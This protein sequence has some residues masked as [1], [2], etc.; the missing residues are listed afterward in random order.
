M[1]ISS[2]CKQREVGTTWIDTSIQTVNNCERQDIRVN[3]VFDKIQWLIGREREKHE[4]EC[5]QNIS[6]STVAFICK[7]IE[8][9]FSLARQPDFSE[10]FVFLNIKKAENQPKIQVRYN[11]EKLEVIVKIKNLGEVIRGRSKNFNKAFCICFDVNTAEVASISCIARGRL[12]VYSKKG[13]LDLQREKIAGI[14]MQGSEFVQRITSVHEYDGKDDKKKCIF[15]SDWRNGNLL[16]LVDG[17]QI[18]SN[19]VKNVFFSLIIRLLEDFHRNGFVHGN[20]RGRKIFYDRNIID[21]EYEFYYGNF[22]NIN[23][24][25]FKL[26]PYSYGYGSRPPEAYKGVSEDVNGFSADVWALGSVLYFVYFGKTPSWSWLT[27]YYEC[28]GDM[29]E[30]IEKSE[31]YESKESKNV[32]TEKSVKLF[33][34]YLERLKHLYAEETTEE[35]KT[36]FSKEF[37]A[38]LR[39]VEKLTCYKGALQEMRD[40]ILKRLD[41]EWHKQIMNCEKWLLDENQPICVKVLAH[42]LNPDPTKRKTLQELV[43]F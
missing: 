3:T 25:S 13:L 5:L 43:E 39:S 33:R 18:D 9:L 17:A 16:D 6:K 12:N 2:D 1:L 30:Q 11:R 34:D 21:S 23:Q 32:E 29:L 38:Y 22:I 36:V 37:F 7:K 31:F 4:R 26:S 42:M 40:F 35:E 28:L 27:H 8:P 41:V 15:F 10:D 24:S 20:I 19:A 14:K